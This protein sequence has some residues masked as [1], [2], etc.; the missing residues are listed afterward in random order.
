MLQSHPRPPPPSFHDPCRALA[1]LIA[2][3]QPALLSAKAIGARRT[4]TQLLPPAVP[5]APIG[6]GAGVGAAPRIS[7]RSRL[8]GGRTHSRAAPPSA[9]SNG[10]LTFRPGVTAVAVA[11]G[12]KAEAA[13]WAAIASAL[14]ALHLPYTADAPLAHHLRGINTLAPPS[15]HAAFALLGHLS[16]ALLDVDASLKAALTLQRWWHVKTAKRQAAIRAVAARIRRSAAVVALQRWY[17]AA[18]PGAPARWQ[19][20]SAVAIQ[21]G[22]V[23]GGRGGGGAVRTPIARAAAATLRSQSVFRGWMARREAAQERMVRALL[24]QATRR[25]MQRLLA[26]NRDRGNVAVSLSCGGKGVWGARWT[27]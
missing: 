15:H 2:H 11:A 12:L 9:A 8:R 3:Y 10:S 6:S 23:G 17:R 4:A 18:L 22:G 26:A 20:R 24:R 1:L 19:R 14:A 13:N 21:V 25:R 5:P 27:E 16:H 7:F